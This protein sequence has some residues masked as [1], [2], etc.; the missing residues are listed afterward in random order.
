M[1][2]IVNFTDRTSKSAITVYD[3]TSSTDTSLTFPGRNVTGYGQ[4]IAENFLALLENFANNTAPVNPV[5]GQLWYNS[6]PTIQSFF[7]WD[8]SQ[9]KSAN[10]I[11]KGVVAPGV[12]TSKK[13]ELWVDTANQQLYVF[14]GSRWILV[15][16]NFSTGLRSGPIVEN[17][18]DSDGN[19][20]VILSFYVE[21]EVIFIISKDSFTPK[22]TIDGFVSIK[23]GLNIT[24]KIIDDSELTSK[25]WSI[26]NSADNLRINNQD[27]PASKFLRSDVLNVTDYGLNVRNNS[28]VIIG[29]DNNF[30]LTTSATASKIYNSIEGS[31]LDLQINRGGIAQTILRILDNKIGIN[32]AAPDEALQV[33]GNVKVDTNIIVTNTA[34]ATNQTNGSI[35]TSGGASIAKNLIIGTELEVF[36]TSSFS[37]TQPRTDV[38]YNLGNVGKRWKNVIA[39][40]VIADTLQG[41]L[42][43]DIDGNSATATALRNSTIFRFS[44]DVVLTGD[45]TF[46]GQVGGT[47]KTFDT[48]L[49]ADIISSKSTPFP[50][51]SAEEDTILAF[52][53][54]VGLIKEE[55]DVFV[56]DLAVPIGA[57]LPFGGA[58]APYGFI[59]CDGSEIEKVKYPKLFNILGYIYG[60]IETLSGVGTFKV[61]DLRG[62][63]P[64]GRDNMDNGFTVP[65]DVGG[66][67][68]SGGGSVGRVEGTAAEV[69]GGSGGNFSTTLSADNLPQHTHSL[70]GDTGRQ[71]YAYRTD[72]AVPADTGAFSGKGSSV[73][74]GGQYLPNTGGVNNSTLSDPFTIMNPYLTLN[75]IIRSGPPEF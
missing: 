37:N 44:G 21:D 47:I 3:N 67:I 69:L 51:L 34:E 71:Y 1:P 16:P 2:Y 75:Y 36:G 23:T 33:S 12:E 8:N 25:L 40:T 35:R 66:Y 45:L 60:P 39:E 74:S 32:V 42:E 19:A 13:G 10:N 48:R 43:G 38:T 7:V 56:S 24:A 26:S 58:N 49:T 14:S 57:I 54:G 9:W 55:R 72:S 30:S 64:L 73:T 11:Q 46:D 61:P 41:K 20:R 53:P 52:R 4:I 15:G 63:F 50:Y 28:G 22:V 27:V 6:D 70:V 17:V 5:E 18:E 29:V 62:R 59:L 65:N 31:S 68:D